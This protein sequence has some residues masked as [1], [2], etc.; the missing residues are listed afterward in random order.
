VERLWQQALEELR[1]QR[2]GGTLA[3]NLTRADLAGDL[4]AQLEDPQGLLS[5]GTID[6]AVVG[7]ASARCEDTLEGP[8]AV[9]DVIYVEPGARGVGVGEALL[10]VASRWAAQRGCIGFDAPALPGQRAAKSF[11]ESMGFTSRLL[12]MHRRM[13]RGS[14]GAR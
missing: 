13:E 8:L 1:G 9:L 4:L 14:G 3:S 11:F 6:A 7:V 10:E 5:V 12:I 2:G